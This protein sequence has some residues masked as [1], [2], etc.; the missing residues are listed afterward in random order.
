MSKV[1]IIGAGNVGSLCAYCLAT[2]NFLEELIILDIIDGLAEGI[3]LDIRQSTAVN[4]IDTLIYGVSLDYNATKN[5]D[6][7][8]ITS[9]IH[10]KPGMS[11]SDLMFTN[12]K[13]INE[14]VPKIL[15][16]SPS[17][18]II[19]VT[20]PLDIL[21]HYTYKIS[22]IPSNKIIG[23]SGILDVARYKSYIAELLHVSAKEID[24]VV[25]GGHGTTM[26]PMLRY[27][28]IGG[29]PIKQIISEEQLKQVVERTIMGGDEIIRLLGRSGWYA[30]GTSIC[31]M[32]ESIINNLRKVL[33]VCAFLNGEYGLRDIYFGVPAILGS[34]GVE[35]IIELD[36]H[37]E[38]KQI[39]LSSAN[40]I[41][42][43]LLDLYK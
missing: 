39:L 27:T 37:E 20:N 15:I 1:S 21:C 19:V 29:I 12:S 36:L 11:R 32:V 33:P 38:E 42:F 17:A 40:S 9:G 2:K 6:V 23:M 25:L 31:E 7:V 16:H 41:K 10:R 26:V 4:Q 18:I 8:V 14:I 3:A 30:A 24:A 28:T 43:G 13:I 5:S 35:K 22:G 34:N